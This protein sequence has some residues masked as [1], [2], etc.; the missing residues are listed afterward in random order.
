M[1][2]KPNVIEFSELSNIVNKN[3]AKLIEL[4]RL[5]LI[6]YKL[7]T[8]KGLEFDRLREYQPSD[9]AKQIDWNATARTM[10][11]HI[12]IFKEERMLDIIFIVDVSNTML[13]GTTELIKNQFAAIITGIF[14]FATVKSGD[15]TGL[16]AFSDRIKYV[17][18]PLMT[19]ETVYAIMK[20]LTTPKYYGGI[21][22]WDVV[23]KSVL[24]NFGPDTVV[25][26]ISDFIGIEETFREDL[27]KMVNK[28]KRVI[29][30]MIRDPRDSYLPK[31]VGKMYLANPN[32]GKVSLVDIEKIREKYNKEAARE[33]RRIE[34]VFINSGALFFKVH[35]NENVT[36]MFAKYFDANW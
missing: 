29:G 31:G 7:I 6:Y 32:T 3:V 22:R 16:L 9:D 24:D 4:F 28:F 25:F 27:S 19:E 17:I 18:E 8:S 11:P 14:A 34:D 30:I 23:P 2:L 15:R 21:R 1:Y 12:K 26:I 5:K 20:I 35:T 13:L 36:D 33:E 10:K